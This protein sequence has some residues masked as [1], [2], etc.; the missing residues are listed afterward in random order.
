MFSNNETIWKLL[1]MLIKHLLVSGFDHWHRFKWSH[2]KL[3]IY[4]PLIFVL[5]FF[6]FC[7]PNFQSI[8]LPHMGQHDVAERQHWFIKRMFFFLQSASVTSSMCH[9]SVAYDVKAPIYLALS[10]L[11][12]N[13]FLWWQMGAFLCLCHLAAPQPKVEDIWFVSL[14]RNIVDKT[15]FI[16]RSCCLQDSQPLPEGLQVTLTCRTSQKA[17]V[18]DITEH[19]SPVT[20]IE[21]WIVR[22]QNVILSHYKRPQRSI[23]MIIKRMHCTDSTNSIPSNTS[24]PRTHCV[25]LYMYLRSKCHWVYQHLYESPL[26]LELSW[27]PAL[28]PTKCRWLQEKNNNE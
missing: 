20:R 18:G 28:F 11:Q 26:K 21:L 23:M 14:A 10:H 9:G 24:A 13:I 25:H 8:N 17:A 22:K 6:Y 5:S 16:F 7:Q 12:D 19:I 3:L 27:P 2:L 1:L 15:W 4:L